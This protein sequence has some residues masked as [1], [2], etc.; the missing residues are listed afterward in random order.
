MAGGQGA[1]A[2]LINANCNDE[3]KA[4]VKQA[5]VWKWLNTTKSGISAEYVLPV[6]KGLDWAVTPHQLR[7]DIYPAPYDGMPAHLRGAT[8][9]QDRRKPEPRQ[10]RHQSRREFIRRHIER[11]T[12]R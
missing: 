12:P 11:G 8:E 7:P 10:R 5:H 2:D 6:A 4:T 1:L 3:N 9:F